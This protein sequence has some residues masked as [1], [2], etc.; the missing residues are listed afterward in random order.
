MLFPCHKPDQCVDVLLKR[1][2]VIF[3]QAVIRHFPFPA[4]HLFKIQGIRLRAIRQP[5]RRGKH[6]PFKQGWA[7]LTVFPA[8]RSQDLVI[9]FTNLFRSL[10]GIFPTPFARS[11]F[12][13]CCS[14]DNRDLILD[15]HARP[16]VVSIACFVYRPSWTRHLCWF[17]PSSHFCATTVIHGFLGNGLNHTTSLL[18]NEPFYLEICWP[19]LR[20]NIDFKCILKTDHPTFET[21]SD[22]KSEI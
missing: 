22:I 18:L 9:P 21:K 10:S 4:A 16:G 3:T 14:S 12:R 2:A 19:K 7:K 15:G 5:S 20:K 13:R 1:L 11:V 8:S 6:E 17:F